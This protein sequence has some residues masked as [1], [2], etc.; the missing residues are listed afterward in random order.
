MTYDYK[1]HKIVAIISDNL[2]SW[3]AMN[4]LGHMAI[5]L[6]AN[7]DEMLMG[8]DVL[9]DKDGVAH[10]GIARFGFII[11][12]GTAQQIADTIAKARNTANMTVVDFPRE[13][14]D[15]RHDDEL[16]VTLATKHN[17]NLEY[18]GVLLYGATSEVDVLTKGFKL[19][20]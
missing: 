9:L 16:T 19:F 3:Q 2:E 4:V 11:K 18:L 7:K 1:S 5:S 20:S 14:L 12:K 15:T 17:S 8:R 13:M 6:G 10:K